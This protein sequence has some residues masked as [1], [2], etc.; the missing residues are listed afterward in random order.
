MDFQLACNLERYD[1]EPARTGPV[2]FLADFLQRSRCSPRRQA[3]ARCSTSNYWRAPTRSDA[4]EFTGVREPAS[5]R[6]QSRLP[7]HSNRAFRRRTSSASSSAEDRVTCPSPMKSSTR[8]ATTTSA[9]MLTLRPLQ[10]H[11]CHRGPS[12]TIPRA[13]GAAYDDFE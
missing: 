10:V 4:S 9:F 7:A 12:L 2:D 3:A 6:C 1:F 5:I 8:Q 13:G 11:D